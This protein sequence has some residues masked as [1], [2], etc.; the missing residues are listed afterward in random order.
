MSLE[1]QI[2]RE[3]MDLSDRLLKK[4]HDLR[5]EGKPEKAR[6]AT[7]LAF[8]VRAWAQEWT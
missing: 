3:L 4:A 8:M 1:K 7:A 6:K 2:H 5:A